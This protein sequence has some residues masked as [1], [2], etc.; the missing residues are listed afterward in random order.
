MTLGGVTSEY[1]T[2][3][4]D[5]FFPNAISKKELR[6]NFGSPEYLFNLCLDTDGPTFAGS[7][8]AITIV[9]SVTAVALISQ[10]MVFQDSL[11]VSMLIFFLPLHSNVS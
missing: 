5:S 7:V 8:E 9:K 10:K 6:S 3:D 2:E 1:T 11:F 4:T